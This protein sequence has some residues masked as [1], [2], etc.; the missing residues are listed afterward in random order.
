MI[1]ESSLLCYPSNNVGF[2]GYKSLG[3]E[4]I[5]NRPQGEIKTERKR[6]RKNQES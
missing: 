4:T 2:G 3:T 1:I 5:H 6:K